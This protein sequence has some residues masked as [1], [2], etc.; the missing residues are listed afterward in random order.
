MVRNTGIIK[1]YLPLILSLIV[2][3]NSTDRVEHEITNNANCEDIILNFGQNIEADDEL[4]RKHER[5]GRP[6]GNNAF[7]AKLE[8]ISSRSLRKRK[9]GPKKHA[10]H[11]N[12]VLCPF[13]F[14]L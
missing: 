2:N 5:T 3:P 11:E 7:L 9:P 6:R 4:L 10:S 1:R 8:K 12:Y 14:L 13:N